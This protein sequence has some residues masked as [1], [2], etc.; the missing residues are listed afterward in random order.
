MEKP[1]GELFSS[2]TKA[3]LGGAEAVGGKGWNLARLE[4][5]GFRIPMGGVLATGSYKLFIEENSL[6]EAVENVTQG[7]TVDNIGDKETEEELSLIREKIRVG[8]I[9]LAVQEELV[10]ELKQMGILERPLAVRSSASA[11]DSVRASFAGV[12]DSFLNVQG[13]DNI[14]KAVRDC[15]ASLWTTRAVAYR[16]KM[17]I[18]DDEVMPAVVIME[19]VDAR[20]AGVSFS[21]DPRNGREDVVLISANFGL[22]ESVVSG[23]VDPDEYILDEDFLLVEKKNGRKEGT[24][25]SREDG[26]TELVKSEKTN[27]QVLSD[28]NIVKLGML[29][30]RVFETLGSGEMHQDIEWAF[31][32]E[33]FYLVQARPVTALPGQT[34]PELKGQPEIWSNANTRDAMPMVQSTLNWSMAKK[35][36]KYINEFPFKRFDYR[37]PAGIQFVKLFQ[38]RIYLNLSNIQWAWYDAYGMPPGKI[39]ESAGG[40]QP[41]IEIREKR[42]YSGIKGFKRLNRLIKAFLVISRVE[43]NSQKFFNRF[44]IFTGNLLK[45]NFNAFTDKEFIDVMKEL[46]VNGNEFIQI[47][48]MFTGKENHARMM[49]LN[50]LEKN[51]KGKGGA[52]SSAIMAGSGDI[53]SA[54]HGYRL[55][56]LAEM[57]RGDAEA[58]KFFSSD[59]FNP[60]LWEKILEESRFKQSFRDFLTEYGHRGVYELDIINPRWREDPTYLLNVIRSTI[61]TTDISK[62]KEAQRENAGRAWQ[63]I[64]RKLPFYRRG[65]VKYLHKKALKGAELREMSKSILVKFFEPQRMIFQEIGRRFAERGIIEY[66]ADIYH[67]AWVEIASILK[68]YWDGRGLKV[69]VAE[70][71]DRRKEM[72]AL[73]PPDFVIGDVPKS[74]EPVTLTSDSAI[75]GIGVSFGNASGPARLIQHPHEGGKLRSGEVL[76]APSTDPGWT[77]LFLRASAIVMETGGFSSHGAIVAR[78]YGIPAVVNIPGVLKIIKDKQLIIVDGDEGKVYI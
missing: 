71:K 30:L 45:K 33:D 67:C 49:L 1:V 77:P 29:V 60:P 66:Q 7:I 73:S 19:M 57:V 10:T 48:M 31:D 53:T 74:A 13:M 15:Y 72:E 44:D 65:Y 43:K 26:G 28:D 38:G 6:R 56:E 24:T 36:L 35:S 34:F 3:Y 76:V 39:N 51:F 55:V 40:H 16:R 46:T 78:E 20:A 64:N 14:L 17:G 12:H 70:R 11:E 68:G 54:Q 50:E 61:E 18:K 37:L 21:C 32:G 23:A 4:R 25:L 27:R 62:L 22:G 47:L 9:P 63:E 59:P 58:Q 41:E 75:T 2:W 69:S 52:L 5:Y 8:F 42:P